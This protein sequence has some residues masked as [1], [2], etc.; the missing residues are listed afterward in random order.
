MIADAP[1]ADE[2]L[3]CRTDTNVDLFWG[4]PK[5]MALVAKPP[6]WGQEKRAIMRGGELVL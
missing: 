1:D 4:S 5:V 3:G 2:E 6:G